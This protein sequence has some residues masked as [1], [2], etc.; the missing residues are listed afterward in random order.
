VNSTPEQIPVTANLLDLGLRNIGLVCRISD[1]KSAF[2]LTCQVLINDMTQSVRT[3]VQLL[4]TPDDP[5]S[6]RAL[7][8][9]TFV[10][11]GDRCLLLGH[12]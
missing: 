8:C 9:R 10:Q 6:Q 1:V 3:S 2:V 11:T 7:D 12:L 4:N 5:P